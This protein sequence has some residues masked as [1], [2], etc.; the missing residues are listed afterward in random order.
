MEKNKHHPSTSISLY[1]GALNFAKG[2]EPV[3][4]NA[5]STLRVGMELLVPASSK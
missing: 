3:A 4:T 2:A 5:G 1:R